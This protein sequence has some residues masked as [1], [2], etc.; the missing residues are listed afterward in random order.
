MYAIKR[1][2]TK[3]LHS[4]SH[5]K[6]SQTS[7]VFMRKL[8]IISYR[9]TKTDLILL[10]LTVGIAFL[11]RAYRLSQQS[12]WFDEYVVIGNAKVCSFREY[13]FLLI[14]N[15]PDY[16]ISPASSIIFYFW[17]NMFPH[18][19]E[20]WRLLPIIAGIFSI[21]IVYL[22]LHE[23]MG[24]SNA[25]WVVL[26]FALSPFN[27]WFH[28]ELKC[29]SFL[30]L[31]GIVSSIALHKFIFSGNFSVSRVGLILNSVSNSLMPWFHATYI[32]F[33]IVQGFILLTL[34]K[35]THIR[36]KVIW[37][38]LNISLLMPWFLWCIYIGSIYFYNLY[39][40]PYFSIGIYDVLIKTFGNDFV[41]L[42]GELIPEWKY[43]VFENSSFLKIFI[44]ITKYL[45]YLG[46]CFFFLFSVIGV[47]R[48]VFLISES[49]GERS[50]NKYWGIFLLSVVFYPISFFLLIGVLI[51][52]SAFHPLYF[53]YAVPFLYVFVVLGLNFIRNIKVFFR[54]LLLMLIIIYL[55]QSFSLI[56]FVNRTNYKMAFNFLEKHASIEDLVIGHRL[57]TFWDV[58]KFYSKRN[59]II[60]H[61]Y[62]SLEG[63]FG[64]VDEFLNKEKK[65]HLWVIVE[66]ITHYLVYKE[67]AVNL[68]TKY[69]LA[70]NYNVHW[71]RFPGHYGVFLGLVERKVGPTELGLNYVY[72]EELK[73]L[74]YPNV[75]KRK[76][77]NDQIYDGESYRDLN[78]HKLSKYLGALTEDN[79]ENLRREEILR[80][81]ISYWPLLPWIK[82]F[83][84]SDLVAIEEVS[85]AKTIAL[86]ELERNPKNSSILLILGIISHLEGNT[87]RRDF[88]LNKCFTSNRMF[89]YLYEPLVSQF[90]GNR[91]EGLNL[92]YCDFVKKIRNRGV[93]T[94]G[95]LF[96]F[97]CGKSNSIKYENNLYLKNVSTINN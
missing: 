13:L 80:K 58:G 35:N 53:F 33:P 38:I 87:S 76:K 4:H 83:V 10:F 5:G 61:S 48:V 44:E 24:R 40:L 41:V 45:G 15:S 26:L 70:Q 89:R 37:G 63:L 85:L 92:D 73:A 7:R 20:V 6:C 55:F 68:I 57:I 28:Q 43:S 19:E 22:Y 77:V 32:T 62:Y 94:V 90:F 31:L 88:Y 36:D 93:C 50:Y 86:R 59:D 30:Q 51:R 74:S 71:K 11:V 79:E 84:L 78:Y 75:C 27:I 54:L 97:V 67:D 12:V 56:F 14:T 23:H 21:S 1:V 65:P 52:E 46:F 49:N 3:S 72:K 81:Y 47:V 69:L 95:E 39:D 82:L 60:Y 9:Y 96:F 91:W 18:F 25:F 2:K 34:Y 8:K 16:G 42:S 17:I 29:Y 64:L 66:P